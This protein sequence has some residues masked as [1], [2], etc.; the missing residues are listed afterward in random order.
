MGV[1]LGSWGGGGKGEGPRPWGQVQ[2]LVGGAQVNTASAE[3][4]AE[5]MRTAKSVRRESVV[6][7]V[8]GYP[9]NVK[10]QCLS[11]G[12]L[13]RTQFKLTLRNWKSINSFKLR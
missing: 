13:M 1:F 12:P 5:P 6:C 4:A 11:T 7:L 2:G 10:E 8:T 9:A 3:G